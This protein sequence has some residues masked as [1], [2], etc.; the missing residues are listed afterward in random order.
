MKL[1]GR[2]CAQGRWFD[3]YGSYGKRGPGLT[4]TDVVIVQGTVDDT[5]DDLLFYVKRV[6]RA[7]IVHSI[8]QSCVV[9]LVA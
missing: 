7:P 5:D 9:A 4:I 3:V 8:T 1:I 6:L 2:I